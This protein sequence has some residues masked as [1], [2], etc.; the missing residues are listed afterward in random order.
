L[1]HEDNKTIKPEDNKQSNLSEII[2][3]NHSSLVD[4]SLVFRSIKCNVV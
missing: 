2:E 3:N 4:C 1:K